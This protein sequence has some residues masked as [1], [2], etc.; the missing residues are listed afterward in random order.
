MTTSGEPSTAGETSHSR[1]QGSATIRDSKGLQQLPTILDQILHFRKLI[2]SNLVSF[3]QTSNSSFSQQ[4]ASAPI[5]MSKP[6]T[7][8]RMLSISY[9]KT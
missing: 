1:A 7:S 3:P 8:E 4:M 2:L 5:S 6:E 9:P